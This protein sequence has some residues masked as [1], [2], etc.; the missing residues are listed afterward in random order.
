MDTPSP[1]KIIE[2]QEKYFVNVEKRRGRK[3]KDHKLTAIDGD[4]L[5]TEKAIFTIEDTKT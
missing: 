1:T 3:K 2:N 4:P 5:T